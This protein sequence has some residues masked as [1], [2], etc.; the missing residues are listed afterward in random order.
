[1]SVNGRYKT[2]SKVAA[3][4]LSI[5]GEPITDLGDKVVTAVFLPFEV[6]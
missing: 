5:E 1:M 3:A 2:N 4:R 6:S